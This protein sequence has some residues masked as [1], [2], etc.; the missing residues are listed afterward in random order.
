MVAHVWWLSQYD[1]MCHAFRAD[2]L[3]QADRKFFEAECGHSVPVDKLYRRR[4]VD[5]CWHCLH[6]VGFRLP[7]LAYRYC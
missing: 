1:W 5:W 2:Q 7:D 6:S 3:E 4:S